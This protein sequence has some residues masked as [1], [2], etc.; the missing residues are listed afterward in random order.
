MTVWLKTIFDCEPIGP[1]DLQPLVLKDAIDEITY[2]AAAPTG[3]CASRRPLRSYRDWRERQ[4]Q[5]QTD[6][7]PRE[8]GCSRSSQ[9][10]AFF[11]NEATST[12]LLNSPERD[13][14][15]GHRAPRGALE[16]RGGAR[17]PPPICRSRL[18]NKRQSDPGDAGKG[19]KQSL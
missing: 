17:L 4:D 5:R 13:L 12:D 9:D 1:F 15:H 14:A 7:T 2:A 6:E 10:C 16:P 18:V 8:T 11:P 3:N 19:G